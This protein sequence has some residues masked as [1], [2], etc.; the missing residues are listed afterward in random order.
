MRSNLRDDAMSG[1]RGAPPAQASSS[2]VTR[3]A[4]LADLE[5]VLVL[6]S[7]VFAS[8]RMS[9]RSVRRFLVSPHAVVLVAEVEGRI[10]GAAVVLV[11]CTSDVARLYSIAV[12]PD[13]AGRGVG[14]ALLAA[15]EDAAC[16]RDCLYLRLE[17]H[18][19][20]ARAIALYRKTG[21]REFGRLHEYYQDRGHA[22]RFEK[23][24]SPQLASLARAPPYFHQTTE[25]TCGPAC[26]LMALAWGDRAF[27]P[28]PA[29]E[30]RLWREATT[31]F[32]SNGLGGCEPFGMAVAL[33]RRGLSSEIFVS[34]PGPYFLDTVRSAEKR[35]VMRIAQEDFVAE[36]KALGLP[37]HLTNADESVAMPALDAGAAAIVLVSG[38]HMTPKGQPHWVFVFGREDRFVL[39]HDPAATRDELGR[40]LAP[41]TYAVPWGAFM[42]MTRCGRDHLGAT[43]LIR[44][45]VPS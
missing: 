43:I 2:V 21:Y 32:M 29:T 27:T 39:V 11:R 30:F 15:A 33:K 23:R 10:C 18:E 7:K 17:V 14:C 1:K 20:N 28:S 34:R 26:L 40:A 8:D 24:L 35:R 25:F 44:K 3:T 6:E 19:N 41:E 31:I 5:P 42:R 37:V 38:Y 13:C 16:A 12:D 45:G 36:A 9:R 4:S 22:L